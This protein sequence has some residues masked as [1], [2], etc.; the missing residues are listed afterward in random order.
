M[1]KNVNDQIPKI[2]PKAILN[3]LLSSYNTLKLIL[4]PNLSENNIH[5]MNSVIDIIISQ[6]KIFLELLNLTEPQ[7]I[8]ELLNINSQNLSKQIAALYEVPKI[9][10]KY[11][12]DS[13]L[14]EK[15][16]IENNTQLYINNKKDNDSLEEQ[17]QIIN[18]IDS[19]NFDFIENQNKDKKENSKDIIKINKNEKI[20]IKINKDKNKSKE[21]EKE[22]ERERLLKKE[23][24]EKD[25]LKEKEMLIQSL[26]EQEKE[27]GREIREKARELIKKQNYYKENSKIQL[28]KNSKFAKHKPRNK[29]KVIKFGN[30]SNLK[31]FEPKVQKL[32]IKK[33]VKPE[34][35]YKSVINCINRTPIRNRFKFFL[36][37]DDDI[38][39]VNL[40]EENFIKRKEKKSKTLF[41]KDFRLPYEINIEELENNDNNKTQ[42]HINNNNYISFNFT[43]RLLD[44]VKKKPKSIKNK[45]LIKTEN[46]R[47]NSEKIKNK[48]LNYNNR[49]N[50]NNY[51]LKTEPNKKYKKRNFYNIN[52]IQK[53]NLN[54]DFFSLDEF[55][56]PYNNSKKGE[57]LFV[58]K[59]GNVLMSKKQKDILEDYINNY[60]YENE[61]NSKLRKSTS[62]KSNKKLNNIIPLTKEVKEKI[63][64]EKRNRKFK[65]KKSMLNYDL[66]DINE[67]IQ[68]LRTS[69]KVPIDDLYLRQ[70]K[71]SLFDRSIF[72][73]CHRLIDN[74]K[75]LENKEDIFTLKTRS[76]SRPMLRAKSYND[77]LVARSGLNFKRVK[78][79]TSLNRVNEIN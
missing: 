9:S 73:I 31:E 46:E 42:S 24:E 15:D 5:F 38:D 65:T 76:K 78:S 67:L 50:Y 21:K 28:K 52:N 29:T 14:L 59:I 16:K 75:E 36:F 13:L 57:E 6:I 3:N 60:L 49:Y 26:K 72:K 45:F 74:Y 39:E 20:N 68:S 53:T 58:T 71:A 62:P 66:N 54:N 34:N 32:K 7:K 79:K 17:K 22:K 10:S 12:K 8:F 41:D 63:K 70:K 69:L 37:D 48:I 23:K 47:E 25:K 77:N 64:K 61:E 43:N 35:R 18:I 44:R 40:K 51:V 33:E 1:S 27:R 55:V 11:F 2:N 30:I 4:S 19:T 56:V